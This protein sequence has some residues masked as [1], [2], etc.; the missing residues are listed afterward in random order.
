MQWNL[1]KVDESAEEQAWDMIVYVFVFSKMPSEERGVVL[2]T[3]EVYVLSE[4]THT[5]SY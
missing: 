1:V 2:R 4:R 3:I 5:W